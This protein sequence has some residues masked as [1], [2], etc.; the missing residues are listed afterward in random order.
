MKH[1]FYSLLITFILLAAAELLRPGFA[2]NFINMNWMFLALLA[3][4]AAGIFL[5]SRKA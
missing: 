4:V 5:K 3:S 1:L 2:T